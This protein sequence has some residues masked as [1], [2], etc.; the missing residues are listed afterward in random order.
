[1]AVVEHDNGWVTR[2]FHLS[3]YTSGLHAGQHVPQGFTLGLSGTTG[4]CTTGP[5]LH[6]ELLVDGKHVD[7]LGITTDD[8]KRETLQ[9]VDLSSFMQRRNLIDVTRANQGI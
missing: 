7:P 3:A 9:G 1:M 2:Y 5:H 4:S 8:A 6:Y